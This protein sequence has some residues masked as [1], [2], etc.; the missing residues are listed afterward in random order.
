MVAG[1]VENDFAGL[2]AET[3]KTAGEFFYAKYGIT[4]VRGQAEAGFPA[5]RDVGLPL[6][7][8]GLSKKL[9]FDQVCGDVLLHLLAATDDTNLIHRSDR[10]TQLKV[11]AEIGKLLQNDPFPSKEVLEKLDREFI[12]KNLSPG[13]SADL[14]ALTLLVL[15]LETV[16]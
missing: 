7:K 9:P 12:E 13:G 16:K 1:I 14:L 10:D 8:E 5:V 11:K 3:A 15:F 4:G 2:T 6:L